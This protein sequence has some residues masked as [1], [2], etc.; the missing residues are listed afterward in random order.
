MSDLGNRMLLVT[1][2]V[3][4]F[5]CSQGIRLRSSESNISLL[6]S[7]HDHSSLI[8]ISSK[9]GAQRADEGVDWWL[10]VLIG[11]LVLLALAVTL[12]FRK[13]ADSDGEKK[14]VMSGKLIACQQ[15]VTRSSPQID[16]V[17]LGVT[18]KGKSSSGEFI[19]L[20]HETTGHEMEG[21]TS[22]FIWDDIDFSWIIPRPL[23]AG[24]P[25]PE[26]IVQLEQYSSTGGLIAV[27]ASGI[28]TLKPPLVGS[29]FS[30]RAVPQMIELVPTSSGLANSWGSLELSVQYEGMEGNTALEHLS[31]AQK[32]ILKKLKV[33][34]P[35]FLASHSLAV[36]LVI[37]DSFFGIRFLFSGCFVS[38]VQAIVSAG[39]I[40]MLSI[41][42]AAEWGQMH[43]HLPTWAVKIGKLNSQFKASVV[44]LCGVPQ[45][46]IAA[47]TGSSSCQPLFEVVGGMTVINFL[48]FSLL[49]VESEANGH[50]AA[51][52]HFN[53]FKR[54]LL[55]PVAN[56]S[57]SSPSSGSYSARRASR[58]QQ[59]L[60]S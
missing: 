7:S 53:C 11:G 2:V 46:V 32:Q 5:E 1:C 37:L 29:P 36:V 12:A 49:F 58:Q 52:F 22:K 15:I 25:S 20:Y 40:A 4:F 54:P 16:P 10:W 35:I 33:V 23:L 56:S 30:P 18:I 45:I 27:I 14:L 60:K 39:L 26:L 47:T 41:P 55:P 51:L 13:P 3:S 43:Y 38:S 57:N 9:L 59:L 24:G 21:S 6:G 50:F 8:S 42:M 48:L 28:V 31:V 44:F 19:E 34:K 17:Q